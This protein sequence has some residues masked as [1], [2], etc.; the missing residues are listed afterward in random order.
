MAASILV[1]DVLLRVSTLLLDAT[2]Q[3]ERWTEREL[4]NWL[5]DAQRAIAKYI[6]QA[7]SRVDAIRL[8]PGTRQ[9]IAEIASSDVIPGD[10]SAAIVVR[11]NAVQDV[12]R[13]MGANGATP[14]RV[15]K[16][17][18]RESLDAGNPD[19]HTAKQSAVIREYAFDPRTPTVFFVSPPAAVGTWV[20]ISYMANPSEI[21]NPGNAY[22]KDG[23]SSVTISIDD[24]YTDDI[25]NYVMARAHMKDA[26][27]SGNAGLASS[28]INI[29]TS[30]INAQ[31]VAL[32]G[33][34]PNLESLPL[35]PSPLASAK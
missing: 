25:V 9:S 19:W 1:R 20:E 30:S 34:N 13:N 12:I 15:I 24:K 16:R 23:G 32:T 2:P 31:A 11:G 27:F 35:A 5:N 4:V 14:G 33:V 22:G 28:F 6:P 7:C 17:I 3:F 21:A 26:E 18:D 29:F 10:G 8:R